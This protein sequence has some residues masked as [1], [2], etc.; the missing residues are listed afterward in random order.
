MNNK[1]LRKEIYNSNKGLSTKL[2]VFFRIENV[3]YKGV[4]TYKFD[5]GNQ[6]IR[7]YESKINIFNPLLYIYFILWGI[8]FMVLKLLLGNLLLLSEIVLDIYEFS[9]FKHMWVECGLDRLDFNKISKGN[10][11]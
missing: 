4:K 6:D 3:R 11:R 1:Q 8:A 2:K 10:L 9:K 5:S 7:L